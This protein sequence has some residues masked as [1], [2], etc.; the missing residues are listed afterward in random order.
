[1]AIQSSTFSEQ[2][3][4]VNGIPPVD[5][6]SAAKIGDSVK[7]TEAD[8]VVFILLFGII[9]NAPTIIVKEGATAAA[10]G[11]AIVF[12]YRLAA[13]GDTLAALTA[14]TVAGVTLSTANDQILVIEVD[15]TELTE[16]DVWVHVETDDPAACLVSC[17][18]LGV[19]LRHQGD[20]LPTM[21]V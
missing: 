1:M 11:D 3:K 14:A 2:F 5:I 9:T 8:K 13:A 19:G 17:V 10:S 21:I 7:M 18:A 20:T 12:N 6:G 4:V 16:G 15:D